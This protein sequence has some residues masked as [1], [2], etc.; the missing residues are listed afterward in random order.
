MAFD[1]YVGGFSRYYAREWENAG[2]KSARENGA[3]YRMIGPD[4]PPQGADWQEVS[5]AVTHWLAAIN[6]GLGDV[7]ARTNQLG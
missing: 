7:L 4:G 2:Q 6:N 1:V 3:E 5:E